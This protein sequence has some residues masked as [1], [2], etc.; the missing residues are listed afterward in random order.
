[1]HAGHANV[2]AARMQADLADDPAAPVPL[3]TAWPLGPYAFHLSNAS[4]RGAA[5]ALAEVARLHGSGVFRRAELDG[6]MLG[7]KPDGSTF[8]DLPSHGTLQVRHRRPAP[9]RPLAV[10]NRLCGRSH[11]RAQAYALDQILPKA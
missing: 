5:A 11:G 2:I 6:G 10:A 7:V 1:M 4:H 9:C 3:D 8:A